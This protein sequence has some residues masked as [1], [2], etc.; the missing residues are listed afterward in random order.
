MNNNINLIAFGTFG[1]PNGFSQTFFGENINQHLARAVKTFDL[2]TNAIKLFPNSKVFGIRKEYAI[3]NNIVSYS[4]Y[5]FA[6]E[7]NSERSGTFIGSTILFNN[8]IADENITINLLNEFQESLISKNVQNDVIIVNHSDKLSVSKPQDFD[9][10]EYH[11]KPIEDLNFQSTNKT[12]VVFCD[13]NPNKLQS[14]FKKSIDLLNMYDTIYFTQ[15]KEVAEFVVQK[16]I[17]E[18]IQQVGNEKQFEQKL[19]ALYEER[20]RKVATSISEFE[21]EVQCLEE[22]K[23][24]TLSNFKEQI[25]QTEKLHQENEKKITESKNELEQVKQIYDDFSSKIKDLANQLKSGKRLDDVKKLYNENRR[26]FIDSVNQIKRP[27]FVSN[28]KK[29]KASTGLRPQSQSDQFRAYDDF[30][31]EKKYHHKKSKIDVFKVSTFLLALLWIGTLSYFLVF[32]SEKTPE[33]ENTEIVHE[34]PAPQ[35]QQ[36]SVSA[37]VQEL[38]PKPNTELN[39]ND[40]RNVAKK[41]TY[42]A[43]VDAVVKL[44]FDK[45]PTDIKSNYLGQEEIYSKRI[46]DLNRNCFE[47]KDGV[48]YFVKDTLKH[49]PSY[50][51]VE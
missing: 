18:L 20:K 7:Q 37:P 35:T 43:K 45:N 26:I 19:E 23:T 28:I 38:N 12:L 51:K 14:F 46:I 11:L 39:E 10:A 31:D 6:K 13:T 48:Y 2:N 50:K 16:G 8:K 15:S 29:P 24:K 34:P 9:K 4:A 32:K 27:N 21:K 17:F 1:N 5:S 25:E 47:E 33:V 3:G 36:Q 49:I 42:S 44:I 40:F 41:L 22:D 30:G